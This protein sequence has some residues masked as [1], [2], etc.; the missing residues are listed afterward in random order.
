MKRTGFLL[1]AM[2]WPSAA[3]AEGSIQLRME[4]SPRDVYIG[5]IITGRIVVTH[6]ADVTILTDT[7]PVTMGSFEVRS[8]AA[9]PSSDAP[10][11]RRTQ[12][13]EFQVLTFS[14]G[15]QNI[16]ALVLRFKGADGTLSEAKTEEVPIQVKSL[17]QEKGD[18]G[19]LRPLKGIF[20]VRSWMWLWILIGTLALSGL[21]Y[22]LWTHRKKKIGLTEVP[23]DPRK[24][25]EI[26][27]EEIQALEDENLVSQGKTKEFYIRLSDI[28][29]TYL[30]RRY[31]ISALEK[32]TSELF[33]DIRE[34][35]LNSDLI[36]TLKT[37]FGTGDLVKFA[38]LTPGEEEIL[39][40][41]LRVKEVVSKT[42]PQPIQE[43]NKEP[44]EEETIQV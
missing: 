39:L 12:T 37:F 41:L 38:K 9:S 44:R 8:W 1:L 11:Q 16:P 43:G 21:F 36:N 31:Q 25:E 2:L 14:T 32:T 7:A 15:T 4:V 27:W 35:G 30:E 24:P 23:V 22:W 18:E 3:G 26:A 40:D 20:N 34:L 19:K 13:T 28:L 5:D 17:L 6:G 29:R 10:N 33:M 42:T